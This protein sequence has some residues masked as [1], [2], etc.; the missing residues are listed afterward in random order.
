MIGDRSTTCDD[1]RDHQPPRPGIY[2]Q[3]GL[4]LTIT[5]ACNLRC[6]YCYVRDKAARHMANPVATR[7]IDRAVAS[8][9][10]GGK[11]ELGFFGGEPLLRA[12]L[13][14]QYAD[15]ARG[16]TEQS[17]H[18]L[19]MQVTTNGTIDSDDAWRVM[20][21][22]HMEL[23]ISCDG[24]AHDRHRKTAAGQGSLDK[25][26]A[27]MRRLLEAGKDFSISMVVRPDT[28]GEMVRGLKIFEQMGVRFVQPT[29]DLWVQWSQDDIA[30]LE[31]AI[32]KATDLWVQ[33]RARF[34][35]GWLDT[36]AGKLAGLTGDQ[37]A[38]CAFGA[39]QIAVTPGGN[40]Y[41]CERLIGGD[42]EGNPARLPGHAMDG[43]DFLDYLPQP[44]RALEACETCTIRK[45][46]QTTCRC[47]NFVRTGDVARPDGLLC[48]LNQIVFEQVC[49]ALET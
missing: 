18:G 43:Q 48:R 40:L 39:G 44:E 15:Y 34:G 6:T 3:F 35:V 13:L 17:S 2:H 42:E 31:Q 22:D 32:A 5:D 45:V 19:S 37:C 33:R 12:D 10:P 27:T 8:L 36:M 25:V 41:P 49:R 47:S 9:A 23:A 14:T 26:R 4:T 20:M 29:L 30:A 16:R 24:A 1:A 38:R 21:D 11:L 28:V 7:S 46:C